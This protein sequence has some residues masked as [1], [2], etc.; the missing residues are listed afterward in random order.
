[1]FLQHSSPWPL[2]LSKAEPKTA[3]D[4][5]RLQ[6]AMTTLAGQD[7]AFWF[8]DA[9]GRRQMFIGGMTEQYLDYAVQRFAVEATFQAPQVAYRE[10]ITRS[11]RL[12]H[13]YSAQFGVGHFARVTLL[14][15]PD[16]AAE[17]LVFASCLAQGA[18]PDEYVA[19]VKHGILSV[20]ALNFP[21]NRPIIG[22][23][24]TL[25][26]AAFHPTDSSYLAFKTAGRAAFTEAIPKLGVQLLEP[27]MKIEVVAPENFV[28]LISNCLTDRR[29]QVQSQRRD[30][31]RVIIGAVT[32]LATMFKLEEELLRLS[33][34][35]AA[36]N[37]HYSH[38]AP[39]P[40]ARAPEPPPSPISAARHITR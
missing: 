1:M 8:A 40:T 15:E 31:A 2:L 29:G 26:D 14:F 28:R 37:A 4:S 10:T 16:L 7:P 12:D 21:A 9:N 20:M 36:L 22:V 38:Y 13:T 6:R 35:Q 17:E 3:A 39:V 27:L 5:I 11:H 19:G 24:A 32:P 30:R 25:I 34:G 18:L 33:A 23:K